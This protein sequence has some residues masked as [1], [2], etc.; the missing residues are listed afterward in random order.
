M[1]NTEE[2]TY[3]DLIWDFFGKCLSMSLPVDVVI[4]R[5]NDRTQDVRTRSPIPKIDHLIALAQQEH[6]HDPSNLSY[7]YISLVLNKLP[8]SDDIHDEIVELFFT[9]GYTII[10]IDKDLRSAD[11]E[12]YAI[13]SHYKRD[14]RE[15]IVI[16]E[17]FSYKVRRG[18]SRTIHDVYMFSYSVIPVSY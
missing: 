6:N 8:D 11:G 14:K 10:N 12:R 15:E 9:L 2:T 7:D 4:V 18:E 13:K 17:W 3:S 5:R 1:D 16:L